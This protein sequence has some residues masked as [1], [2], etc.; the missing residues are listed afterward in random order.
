[1]KV[2]F[3]LEMSFAQAVMRGVLRGKKTCFH[4]EN[5]AVWYGILP[6]LLGKTCFIH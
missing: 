2:T 5:R 4:R 3:Y 1:M 6:F